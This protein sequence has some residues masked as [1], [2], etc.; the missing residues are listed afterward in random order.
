MTKSVMNSQMQ[1]IYGSIYD[2]VKNKGYGVVSRFV[3]VVGAKYWE[4]P[5]LMIVGRATNGWSLFNVQNCSKETFCSLTKTDAKGKDIIYDFTSWLHDDGVEKKPY[6]DECYYNTNKSA[7]FRTARNFLREVEYPKLTEP[8]FKYCVW[9]NLFPISPETGNPNNQLIETELKDSIALL[10]EEIQYFAPKRILFVT[11]SW[12]F[13][14]FSELFGFD[15]AEDK[16]GEYVQAENKYYG[17]PWV[18]TVRPEGKKDVEMLNAIKAA[19]E[20]LKGTE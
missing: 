13:S 15:V 11:G 16:K 4:S 9:T 17:I 6:E 5:E 7:F 2:A 8:W 10:K 3:P 20:R 12:W 1:E 19:F 14:R 18:M